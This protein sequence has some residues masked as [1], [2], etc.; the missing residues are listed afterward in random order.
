MDSSNN[1][2][3][4]ELAEVEVAHALASKA[5]VFFCRGKYALPMLEI[6]QLLGGIPA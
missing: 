5:A 3:S 2:E 4:C 1:F 6:L